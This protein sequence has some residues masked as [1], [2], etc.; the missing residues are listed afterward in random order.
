VRRELKKRPSRSKSLSL[1]SEPVPS[2][3][4]ARV[5]THSQLQSDLLQLALE[6][7]IDAPPPAD[8]GR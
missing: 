7:P 8:D 5:D 6:L 2:G 4:H 1:H 3:Q